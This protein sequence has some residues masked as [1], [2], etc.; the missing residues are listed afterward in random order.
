MAVPY[1]KLKGHS[2]EKI[3]DGAKHA[4]ALCQVPNMG[5]TNL[6]TTLYHGRFVPAFKARLGITDNKFM[7]SRSTLEQVSRS[8]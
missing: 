2:T 5:P 4:L 8:T 7:P 6:T 1:N 3:F